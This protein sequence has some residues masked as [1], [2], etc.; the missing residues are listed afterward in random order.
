M[1]FSQDMAAT[2]TVLFAFAVLHTFAANP[3]RRLGNKFQRGSMGEHLMHYMGEVEAIFGFWAFALLVWLALKINTETSIQYVESLNF[4]EALFV[5][6]VMT[7]SATAPILKF[8]SW[9]L[10]L[11]SRLFRRHAAM[12]SYLTIM[13]FGPLLGSFI[14]EPAAMTVCA[15]LLADRFFGEELSHRFRYATLGLLFVNVSVGGTLTSYA[16][17]P[18]LMVAGKWGW[19]SLFMLQQFGSKVFVGISLTT[20]ATAIIFRNEFKRVKFAKSPQWPQ[21][22]WWII[23]VHLGFLAAIVVWHQRPAFFLPLL[24]LFLGWTDVSR[25]HQSPLRL[26]E[27]LLVSLFLGGIVVLGTPQGWWIQALLAR[28][29]DAG[30]FVGAAA[31]TAITDNAA[32]TYLGSMAPDIT[33]TAQYLLVAGAVT[34]GGL[35]VIANAPNPAGYGILKGSFGKDG[36]SALG[37]FLGAL[38]ATLVMGAIFW[39]FP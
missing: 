29:S 13:I 30:L 37:L 33:P 3:I 4:T 34:G 26:R 19:D 15:L 22:P 23:A 8:A 32:I 9:A 5:F 21:S 7:V 36:I 20:I 25:S 18:V 1:V 11:P 38:P 31:L 28:L 12:A 14:T 17:P 39:L 35:T 10:D 6:C 27:S 24:L 16:A 2:T